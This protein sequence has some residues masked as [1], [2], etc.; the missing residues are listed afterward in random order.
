M[1]FNFNNTY[2]CLSCPLHTPK[3]AYFFFPSKEQEIFIN[4]EDSTKIQRFIFWKPS[5][6]LYTDYE[7]GKMKEFY[8]YYKENNGK[9]QFFFPKDFTVDE[10]L[11][12]I[13][14]GYWDNAKI[15]KSIQNYISYRNPYESDSYN[16]VFESGVIYMHGLTSSFSPILILRVGQFKELTEKI[17]VKDFLAAIDKFMSYLIKHFF[18]PGQVERWHMIID[19]KNFKMPKGNMLKEGISVLQ[20]KYLCRLA[21][22]YFLNTNVM[23]NYLWKGISFFIDEDTKKKFNIL[24]NNDLTPMLEDINLSQIEQKYGGKAKDV[25]D[26]SFPFILPGGDITAGKEKGKII[27]ESEYVNLCK[28]NKISVV[29]PYISSSYP[30]LQDFDNTKNYFSENFDKPEKE[31]EKDK[32]TAV[33]ELETDEPLAG[34][35]QCSACSIF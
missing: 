15:M 24:E 23:M 29:S 14:C 9:E 33:A 20:G 8:N 7:K 17:E 12:N 16:K 32:K 2:Q 30:E 25:E 13:Q 11:R 10:Y 27:S 3:E 19:C 34:R 1:S 26:Y 28:E 21:R 4:P 6:N 5:Y 22:L 35:C 18:I 31:K